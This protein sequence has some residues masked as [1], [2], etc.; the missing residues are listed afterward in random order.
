MTSNLL[1]SQRK[2]SQSLLAAQA[3]YRIAS[4]LSR[5]YSEDE[6]ILLEAAALLQYEKLNKG[7]DQPLDLKTLMQTSKTKRKTRATF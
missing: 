5:E 6:N 1:C 4:A 2:G 7:L 3:A